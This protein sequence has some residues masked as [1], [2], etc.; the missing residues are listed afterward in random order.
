M[1]SSLFQSLW[2]VGIRWMLVVL[3]FGFFVTM[4]CGRTVE[5]PEGS[6]TEKNTGQEI[7]KEAV[8][9]Q[10][11]GV[12]S[13]QEVSSQEP[14]QETGQETVSTPEAEA[15]PVDASSEG[16]PESTVSEGSPES[17]VI[18]EEAPV[19]KPD[20]RC[21]VP[22]PAP[23]GKLC[24]VKPGNNT[25][26]FIANI[27]TPD[28][29]LERGHLLVDASGKIQCVGCDCRAQ[30]QGA[31]EIDCP[32]G[33]LTPGLINAHEH[34]G[35]ALSPPRKPGSTE[36][37][38]HR[39]HWRKGQEGHTSI[40]SGSSNTSFDAIAWAEIRM[41][42]SGATSIAGSGHAPG[43]LR[44]L[45]RNGQRLGVPGSLLY[46]TFPLG[47]SDGQTS[48]QGCSTW[49]SSIRKASTLSSV[50]AY[51]PHISEGINT[52]ARN[53]F[54]CTSG[55]AGGEL[56]VTGKTG[57]I[58]GIGL[59]ATDIRK[60]ATLGASL[61][62]SPRSNIDLYADTASVPLF[63]QQG[64][65][66]A[67]GTDWPITGSMNML[68]ELQCADYLNQNHFN[69]TINDRQLLRM[70]TSWA[71]K[72][73]GASAYLG[74]LEVGKFA[75]LAL[76]DGTNNTGYR[77]II[78][79]KPQ[80]VALVVRGGKPLYGNKDLIDALV[81][82]SSNLCEVLNVCGNDKQLCIKD[83][84]FSSGTLKTL[85]ELK[86]KFPSA[87]DLF[88]CQTPKDE[89]SCVPFR[90]DKYGKYGHSRIDD[91]DGDGVPDSKDNC[92]DVFN[93]IRPMDGGKQ[94][95]TD[96]DGVGDVCD[97]CPFDANTTQC[98]QFDPN[99]RDGDGIPNATDNCPDHPNPKQ[100]DRDKDG[101]GD[102]CDPC[103]DQPNKPGESCA[104][105]I[106]D[107]KSGVVPSGTKVVLKNVLVTAIAANRERVFVQMVSTDPGYKGVDYSG[108][109]LYLGPSGRTYPTY[110]P[111]QRIDV[112][113]DAVDYRGQIQI[114]NVT[115]LTVATTQTE[116]LPTPVVVQINEINTPTASKA[117]QLEGVLV[118]I[119]NVVVT[120]AN[121][122]GPTND[123][124]E[125]EV[126]PSSTSSD[127]LRIDDLL[128]T[129]V[130]T[131]ST[132]CTWNNNNTGNDWECYAPK[133]CL[134]PQATCA[135]GTNGRCIEQG[136]QPLPDIRKVGDS[137]QSLAGP[138]IYIFNSYKIVPRDASDIK[139]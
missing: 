73:T 51:I 11:Q 41:I 98:K 24:T 8:E 128:D 58:H 119:N 4:S 86:A 57:I 38:E 47:D 122:D 3:G 30:A 17:T 56:L 112:E 77:A 133:K 139:K 1:S 2:F 121:P 120:N 103:P 63:L 105:S 85:A 114:S 39:H 21:G 87:Y 130:Y 26:L 65:T 135:A 29:W 127:K 25:L 94:A 31:T 70:A 99:D 75:D 40:P 76:F 61:I 102:V 48:K 6:S 138:L 35:W 93:P 72:A 32:N 131:G 59:L 13:G 92:P 45:D 14:T 34:L 27:L 53:E 109:M 16:L 111:G 52:E 134:C 10:N 5:G 106:H 126:A 100:E 44:N 113:G 69:K 95:D 54:L 64:V 43:L 67:L 18:P 81:S 7:S 107:I 90:D 19:G 50:D 66:V 12:E 136:Q 132:R 9:E 124:Q 42:L 83:E 108:L 60:M 78:D 62:W 125:F 55:A 79:A 46:D 91:R 96:G 37:Y 117:K 101:I 104:V 15:N 118:Q 68:R 33:Y 137:F 116:T 123:Y 20:Q 36:R 88:A 129:S 89:P 110:Q 22:S 82:Q 49:T 28:Q 97:V 23:S 115:K 84:N 71:A 80:E 74:T